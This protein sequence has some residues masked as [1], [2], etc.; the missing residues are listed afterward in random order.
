MHSLTE[1]GLAW[2]CACIIIIAGKLEQLKNSWYTRKKNAWPLPLMSVPSES[3]SEQNWN[4]RAMR[5]VSFKY[6]DNIMNEFFLAT[7]IWFPS[8]QLFELQYSFQHDKNGTP[9]S[10]M[11]QKYFTTLMRYHIKTNKNLVSDWL[12]SRQLNISVSMPKLNYIGNKGVILS[13]AQTDWLS[14]LQFPSPWMGGTKKARTAADV[15][16]SSCSKS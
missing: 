10:R 11:S 2:L 7:S 13:T 5:H 1:P 8:L 6:E 3:P 4:K 14:T 9:G 15:E 12:Y 16:H